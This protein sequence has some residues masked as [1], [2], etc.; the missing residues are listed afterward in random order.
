MLDIT[1]PIYHY[2]R[3]VFR[4]QM[5]TRILGASTQVSAAHQ[6][7]LLRVAERYF[8]V[9]AAEDNLAFAQAEES[10]LGQQ[11]HQVQRRFDLGTIPITDLHE[12]QANYDLA[13]A[14]VIE[15]QNQVAINRAQL[16]EVI[17]EDL[18]ALKPLR[19]DIPISM[20]EPA[21]VGP[22]V[23][24]A[25]QQNL[26]IAA[27]NYTS[28]EAHDEIRRQSADHL[29]TLDLRASQSYQDTGGRVGAT[30]VDTS[31]SLNLNIPIYEGGQ[32]S[33]RTR[34]AQHRHRATLDRL[35]QQRRSVRQQTEAAFLG[36]LSSEAVL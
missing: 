13:A 15:T 36:V 26:E 25:L 16:R 1:Q 5:E 29:P 34:Q 11:L 21:A 32:T 30:S 22:W 10:A 8:E 24:T 19:A 20:P 2:D 6:K 14:K 33:S 27:A 4:D 9:H 7:L 17:D 28:Q 23:D 12:A 31:I 18:E 3:F 35:E